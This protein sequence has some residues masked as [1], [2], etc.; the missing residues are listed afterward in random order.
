MK[1]RPQSHKA[2]RPHGCPKSARKTGPRSSAKNK[3]PLPTAL[4]QFWVVGRGS[5]PARRAS[6]HKDRPTS[7]PNRLAHT[8][9]RLGGGEG[10]CDALP[11]KKEARVPSQP[12]CHNSGWLGGGVGRSD[13]P[14]CTKTGPLPL[15][16]ASP[17]IWVAGRG[18]GPARVRKPFCAHRQ[19]RRLSS[20]RFLRSSVTTSQKR[21]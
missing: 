15:P 21:A 2:L 20:W 13:A 8:L 4:P 14:P 3:A 18:R 6:A 12:P 5:G 9:G 1:T 11:C 10:R 16:D 17:I 7:P 19:K